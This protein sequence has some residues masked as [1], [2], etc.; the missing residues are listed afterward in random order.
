MHKGKEFLIKEDHI[1]LC[2]ESEILTESRGVVTDPLLHF[3]YI[4]LPA[5]VTE[6]S[7]PIMP[8]GLDKLVRG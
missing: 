6:V 5:A 2:W 1:R 7:C 8:V 4:V 3:L